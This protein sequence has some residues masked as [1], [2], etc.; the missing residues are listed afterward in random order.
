M[1][2]FDDIFGAA[3]AL[4]PVERIRLVQELWQTIP[5]DDWPAPST[6]WIAE[7]QRRSSELDA[8]RMDLL[9]WEEVRNRARHEAG[10]DG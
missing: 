1:P 10:L 3:E 4:V 9:P 6:E 2:T 7:A 8:G 5:P